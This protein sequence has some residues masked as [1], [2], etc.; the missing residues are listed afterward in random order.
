[1]LEN[2]LF[3]FFTFRWQSASGSQICE[4]CV[5]SYSQ[6]EPYNNRAL[7]AKQSWSTPC[8]WPGRALKRWARRNSFK[9]LN[10]HTGPQMGGVSGG[11]SDRTKQNMAWHVQHT[12]CMCVCA[13]ARPGSITKGCACDCRHLLLAIPDSPRP[14][15]E[16]YQTSVYTVAK[17]RR[18]TCRC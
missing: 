6:K 1:M 9:S 5:G 15:E 13:R 16:M 7:F 12:V 10:G 18:M 8:F 17:T 3:Y 14:A 11:S 2:L 4:R